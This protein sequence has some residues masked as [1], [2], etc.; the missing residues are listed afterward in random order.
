MATMGERWERRLDDM[1]KTMGE[2]FAGRME[3]AMAMQDEKTAAALMAEY[4]A[5]RYPEAKR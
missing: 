4:T 3:I 2:A 5:K 1:E